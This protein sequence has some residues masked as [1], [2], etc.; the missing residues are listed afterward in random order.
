MLLALAAVPLL[1]L[2]A[3]LVGSLVP[4]NR[5]W[6]EPAEG[7]T[8]YLRSNGI[9]VDIIMPAEAEGLDWGPLFPAS[10]FRGAPA[11]ARWFAFGAGERRVYLETP[12]WWDL[13][14]RTVWAA[15]V[16]GE[17]VM[18][19][20]RTNDPG[21]EL[22]AVRLRPEEYRRLWAAIRAELTLDAEGRPERIEHP[23]YTPEDAFFVGRGRASAV[24]S[25]NTWVAER[26]RI[27]G[28]E[29]SLWSPFAQGL[30]WRYRV[31]EP[32]RSP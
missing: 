4:V 11:D 15:L 6:E 21:A 27:A 7:T 9:H 18:H 22:R 5:G 14:P 1:Y 12:T 19:V 30:L 23:G 17:R 28:V 31:G 24:S 26:L 29:A 10:S 8:V 16:G 2:A 32:G 13:S 25:C 3:A 20:E